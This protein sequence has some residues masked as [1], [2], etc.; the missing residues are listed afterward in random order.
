MKNVLL[1]HDIFMRA[2]D[3]DPSRITYRPSRGGGAVG[4]ARCFV[5]W[6]CLIDLVLVEGSFLR[7]LL[8][9]GDEEDCID[10]EIAN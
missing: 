8:E 4:G 2:C 1:A 6:C 7:D 3:S 10:L 5:W 9:D